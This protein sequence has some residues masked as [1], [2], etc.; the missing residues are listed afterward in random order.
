M[1][2]CGEVERGSGRNRLDLVAIR[3]L[4]WILDYF[5]AFYHWQIG[6]IADIV[7]V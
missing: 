5:P 1:K 6:R 7:R 3:I 2:F 4:S